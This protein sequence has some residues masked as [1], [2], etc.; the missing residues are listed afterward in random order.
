MTPSPMSD[1]ER[2][3]APQRIPAADGRM[4]RKLDV[5]ERGL[6]GT[7]GCPFLLWEERATRKKATTMVAKRTARQ[8]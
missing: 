6:E 5:C 8:R 4:R 2:E 1:G 3:V 7:R